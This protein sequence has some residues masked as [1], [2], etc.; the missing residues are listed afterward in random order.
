MEHERQEMVTG[1]ETIPHERWVLYM[2]G[3][4]GR[5]L[6]GIQIVGYGEDEQ[7]VL[8]KRAGLSDHQISAKV[9]LEIA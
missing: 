7:L 2:A 9:S 6:L 4:D 1:K 8:R 5:M 3:K